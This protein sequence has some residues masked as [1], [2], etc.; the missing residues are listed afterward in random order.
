VE[1]GEFIR[2][3]FSRKSDL[4]SR[5]VPR[6]FADPSRPDCNSE[7]RA[8]VQGLQASPARP[9]DRITV[10]PG[11]F[12]CG[13]TFVFGGRAEQDAVVSAERSPGIGSSPSNGYQARFLSRSGPLLRAEDHPE[14]SRRQTCNGTA[15]E[16]CLCAVPKL[17]AT[18]RS[19]PLR[20][21]RRNVV[22]EKRRGWPRS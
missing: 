4:E 7:S 10:A 5:A 21:L 8:L 19:R 22:G 2:A 14:L 20:L 15:H 16:L 12:A 18:V 9:D 13:S 6:Y 11:T 17:E 1:G 3:G